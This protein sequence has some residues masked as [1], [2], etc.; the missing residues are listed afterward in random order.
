[1]DYSGVRDELFIAWPR[2]G[3]TGALGN[4]GASLQVFS[5]DALIAVVKDGPERLPLGGGVRIVPAAP[6]TVFAIGHATSRS[7]ESFTSYADFQT[8]LS[9][10][11]SANPKPAVLVISAHG[12]HDGTT[13]PATFTAT[14]L[15]I[16][17]ND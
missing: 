8:R 5:S 10:L 2:G 15:A 3:S 11:M 9:A 12:T 17:L 14:R 6:P 13:V 1:V 16:G 7:V 4:I